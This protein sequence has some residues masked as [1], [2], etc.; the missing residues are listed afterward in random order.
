MGPCASAV[1]QLL[2]SMFHVTRCRSPRRIWS[3]DE[4]HRNI[5]SSGE[6]LELVLNLNN[7]THA[8]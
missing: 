7:D 5:T 2:S 6:S 3:V 8:M 4:G 1:M